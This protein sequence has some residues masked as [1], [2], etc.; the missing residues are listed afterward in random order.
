VQPASALVAIETGA[1]P[2][3]VV[4]RIRADQC[5]K[6]SSESVLRL[7]GAHAGGKK[8]TSAS[9]VN[10]TGTRVGVRRSSHPRNVVPLVG[11]HLLK[12]GVNLIVR[13]I[14]PIPAVHFPKQRLSLV[15]RGLRV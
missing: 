14:P 12:R 1:G 13:R 7:R 8:L 6:R 3:G 4:L 15:A 11:L 9:V 2:V 10:A 5:T